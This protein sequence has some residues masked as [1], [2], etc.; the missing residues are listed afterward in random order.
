[1]APSGRL[2]LG[3]H[4]ASDPS[5]ADGPGSQGSQSDGLGPLGPPSSPP[6]LVFRLPCSF[7]SLCGLLVH[8][9]YS[10]EPLACGGM[11]TVCVCMWGFLMITWKDIL[12]SN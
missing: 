6:N 1:M 9:E 8:L 10:G 4:I 7:P 12:L 5:E 11:H 3:R 2:K